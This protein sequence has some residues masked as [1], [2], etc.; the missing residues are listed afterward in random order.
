MENKD[1]NQ[2]AE[3]AGPVITSL[4]KVKARKKRAKKPASERQKCAEGQCYCVKCKKPTKHVNSQIVKCSNGRTRVKGK[5]GECGGNISGYCKDPAKC[6]SEEKNNA[7]DIQPAQAEPTPVK[8]KKVAKK[9]E[10]PLE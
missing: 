4:K 6:K 5:C 1:E 7:S 9:R 10:K 8:Q 2:I 3:P